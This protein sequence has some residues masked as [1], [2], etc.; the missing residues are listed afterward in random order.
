M[1]KIAFKMQLAEGQLDEYRKRHEELWPDLADLLKD[2]GISDY[3]IYFD[4][5]THAL[6]AVLWRSDGHKMDSLQHDPVMKKWW[7][8]MADIMD[9]ESSNAPVVTPLESVFHFA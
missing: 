3:S 4:A 9:T 7:D 5:T 8:Y 2:A 6:F 1:E